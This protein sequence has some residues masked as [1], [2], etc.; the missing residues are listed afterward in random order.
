MP[1]E[2]PETKAI[3][4]RLD[5]VARF[6]D[7]L[8]LLGEWFFSRQRREILRMVSG[9]I[10]E[11]GV[12]TGNSLKD[13]PPAQEITAIDI[14][15]GMLLRAREKL[16]NHVGRVELRREDVEHLPFRNEFFDTIFTS[17]VFCTVNDPVEGL[18]ELNRVL[19]PSGRL[20]MLEHVKSKNR[21]FGYLMDKINPIVAKYGIDNINRDTVQNLQKAGFKVKQER[22]V[23]YDI[24]KVIVAEK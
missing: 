10:L 17:L 3:A 14:S 9:S 11:V 18:R 2:T 20:L 12:G 19:K 5:R 23:A 22:N 21:I 24:L 4:A 7:A 8:F 16:V 1:N 6:Y 15:K 13:Y